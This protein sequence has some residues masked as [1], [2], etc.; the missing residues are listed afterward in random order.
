MVTRAVAG[1]E[2]LLALAPR[3]PRDP[4]ATLD[5]AAVTAASRG[6]AVARVGP[7]AV[8]WAVGIGEEMAERIVAEIPALGS[9]TAPFEKLRSGTEASVLRALLVLA[10]PDA[11]LSPIPPESLDGVQEFVRRGVSLDGVLRG[12]RLGHAHM[13]RSFLRDCEDLVAPDRVAAEMASVTDELFVYIDG[14]AGAMTREYLTEYDRWTTSAAATRAQT[15]RA[16]LAGEEVDP[17]AAG[18]VLDYDL[19]RRHLGLTMWTGSAAADVGL[20]R[21]AADLLRARGARSALVVPVGA[22]QLW[23]WGSLPPGPFPTT[24]PVPP[25]LRVAFGSA[26]AGVDGFRRTHAEA[27]R[28]E[29]LRRVASSGADVDGA[30]DYDD[31]AVAAL[32]AGDVGAARDFV[33]RELG[34]LAGAGEQAADLRTTLLHYLVAERSL[35]TVAGELHIARGTVAYRVKRAEQLLG[36]SAGERRLE[37][38]T[39]LVLARELGDAVL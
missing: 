1:R 18:R 5:H 15:V 24:G 39:A 26:G 27:Q 3:D 36:R 32:L 29:R 38:H 19:A 11:G 31:V 17:V 6:D 37:L 12:I 14:F 2:W 33:R 20:Q 4:R 16:I 28:V 7:A 22:G 35:I 25:G 10:Q 23:A 9:G 30:T 34:E 8:C 13:T 21:A